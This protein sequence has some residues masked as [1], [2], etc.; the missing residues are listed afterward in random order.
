MHMLYYLEIQ[1]LPLAHIMEDGAVE[2]FH[3]IA[4]AILFLKNWEVSEFNW[5]ASPAA[6]TYA[7]ATY[8]AGANATGNYDAGVQYSVQNGCWHSHWSNRKR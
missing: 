8:T 3:G 4:A 2:E 7:G 1:V 5:T 6:G